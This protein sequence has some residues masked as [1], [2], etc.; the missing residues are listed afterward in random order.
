LLFYLYIFSERKSNGGEANNLESKLSGEPIGIHTS[1][2]SNNVR[3]STLQPSN[4]PNDI[5]EQKPAMKGADKQNQ[6]VIEIKQKFV[7]MHLKNAPQ[8]LGG[9]L[10]WLDQNQVPTRDQNIPEKPGVCESSSSQS[11]QSSSRVSRVL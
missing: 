5:D 10:N 8:P 11:D 2:S 1:T 4:G 6:G 7:S 9:A 3:L